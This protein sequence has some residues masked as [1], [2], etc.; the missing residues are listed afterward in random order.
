MI[1]ADA[2]FEPPA[3]ESRELFGVRLVQDRNAH[4]IGEARPRGGRVRRAHA[5][6]RARPAARPRRAQVHA[7]ELGGLRARRADDRD[8]RRPAVA[9]RLHQARR[10]EGR[11]LAPA[12]APARCSALALQEGREAPGPHQLARAL[13]RGRPHAAP[14]RRRCARRSTQ[15]LEL[16]SADE[17]RAW[18]ARLRRRLPGL[19]RLH[20]VPRQ[21]RPRRSATASRFIAEPGGSTR[22]DEVEAACREYGITLV[23]TKL[24]LFHH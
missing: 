11:P 1:R 20:P 14:R 13:H 17:Q 10:R 7:V 9:R 15:P 8:R 2:A 16:L 4:A 21:H 3:R 22:D 24:R 19:R 12:P 5:P 6:R 18:L 23:H